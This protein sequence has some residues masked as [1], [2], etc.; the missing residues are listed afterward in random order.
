MAPGNHGISGQTSPFISSVVAPVQGIA[1]GSVVLP[2]ESVGI[3]QRL[4]AAREKRNEKREERREKGDN[5]VSDDEP[6]ELT[7]FLVVASERS[8]PGNSGDAAFQKTATPHIAHSSNRLLFEDAVAEK[9]SFQAHD[10]S[11]PDA[12]FSLAKNGISPPLTLFLPQSLGR[13]RSGNVKTV[14]HGTGETTRVTVMDVSEFPDEETLDQ[15]TF[16]TCYN[17]FLTFLEA[18]A[19]ARIFRGFVAHYNRILSDPDLSTWFA[20]YQ[21]FD[22]KIRAQFFT[23]P[24]II[25]VQDSQ[26]RDALQSAK[27]LLLMSS[28]ELDED[29]SSFGVVRS[30]REKLERRQPYE[31]DDGSHSVLCF[32]CG[33]MGH[34]AVR[35]AEANP[36]RHGRNFVI[37]ATREGLFRIHDNRPVCMRYNC[38]SCD[39]SGNNHAVH[40]CSL[41]SDPHHGAVNCTRN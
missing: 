1:R 10:N 40:I 41:C 32:R 4:D 19:G 33:R 6:D 22:K 2:P 34:N 20:A 14:K 37:T 8:G 12:V 39:A 30:G 36:S 38:G 11:I 9:N 3:L 28:S 29:D 17:T 25:D 21:V 35:C 31:R 26:Y 18:S 15:A 27:N 7:P 13:L 23:K 5:E 24:Y 16:L